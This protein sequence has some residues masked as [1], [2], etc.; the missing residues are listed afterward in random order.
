MRD[1]SGERASS[2]QLRWF[3]RF[4]KQ[5][6]AKYEPESFYNAFSISLNVVKYFYFIFMLYPLKSNIL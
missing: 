5:S 4:I 1:F 3:P 2:K 6:K